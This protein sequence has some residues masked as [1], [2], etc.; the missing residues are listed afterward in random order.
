[1]RRPPPIAPSAIPILLK[2]V[3]PYTNCCRFCSIPADQAYRSAKS[4]TR[5][6]YIAF[7]LRA[8]QHPRRATRVLRA[9]GVEELPRA[10]GADDGAARDPRRERALGGEQLGRLDLELVDERDGG[11][12]RPRADRRVDAVDLDH[13]VGRRRA[14]VE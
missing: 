4:I 7:S 10:L 6:V 11:E 9:G 5:R 12:R 8:A 2:L 3:E 14:E 13:R 1:M